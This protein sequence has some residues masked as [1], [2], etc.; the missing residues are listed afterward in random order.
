M[1]KR[2]WWYFKFWPLFRLFSVILF[3]RH[4]LWGIHRRKLFSGYIT[5]ALLYWK[6]YFHLFG[7]SVIISPWI[8]QSVF[9]P[10]CRYLSFSFKDRLTEAKHKPKQMFNEEPGRLV[11]TEQV[12]YKNLS[13][14]LYL[15]AHQRLSWNSLNNLDIQLGWVRGGNEYSRR[16]ILLFRYIHAVERDWTRL[17]KFNYLSVGSERERERER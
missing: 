12:L 8:I 5:F 7:Q 9:V 4:N 10:I 1:Q 11:K 17:S 14:N 15:F 2:F 6:C 13:N 3:S 16:P